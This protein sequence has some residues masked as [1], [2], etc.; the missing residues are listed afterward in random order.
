MAAGL[1]FAVLILAMADHSSGSWCVCKDGIGDS[2]LQKTLDYACGAGA[3]CN[4]THQNGPCF[5]PNTVKSHCS[6]AVN[7]YFQRN[8][9]DPAACNFTGTA[10]IVNSDPSAAGCAYPST[11][12]STSTSTPTSPVTTVSGTPSTTTTNG[13]SPLVT[14]PT[15]V[16]GG[17]NNGLG[18]SGINDVS[19]GGI[20]LP[21]NIIFCSSILLAFAGLFVE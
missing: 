21:R 6:Y 19:G 10:T 17:P 15:G 3:D 18:P 11:A 1:V 12:S 4:P 16:L 7:S 9:Q 13:G 14:T 2:T 5:N 8:R 20:R